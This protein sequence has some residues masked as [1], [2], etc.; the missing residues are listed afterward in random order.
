MI[1]F[2]VGASLAALAIPAGATPV[3]DQSYGGG[4]SNTAGI[5]SGWSPTRVF[6]TVTAGLSG[7]LT[8]VEIWTGDSNFTG[9]NVLSTSGGAPTTSVLGTG[10]YL[11]TSL[12]WARFSVAVPITTGEVF[13]IE[14]IS[15]LAYWYGQTATSYSGG[16]GY[17]ICCG[18]FL[19]GP[20]ADRG[21]RTYV[22][23]DL[24]ADVPEP[25][26]LGLFGLGAIGLVRRR[27][28]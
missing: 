18:G 2:L 19:A 5:M 12:G 23:A 7:M 15:P 24:V 3:L 13:A 20:V 22:D 1:R 16:D 10:T 17:N 26:M 11:S 28:A 8:E 14:P 25:A 9:F 27:K 6:Q 21:F 4:G